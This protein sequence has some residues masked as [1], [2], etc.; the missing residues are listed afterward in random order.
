MTVS[1]FMTIVATEIWWSSMFHMFLLITQ[2]ILPVMIMAFCYSMMALTIW[3][4]KDLGLAE[5]ILFHVTI[6]KNS[7]R[8]DEIPSQLSVSFNFIKFEGSFKSND[9][10]KEANAKI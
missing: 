4:N 7:Y 3:K 2:Y 6:Q 10:E 5:V 9:R 8:I 1:K